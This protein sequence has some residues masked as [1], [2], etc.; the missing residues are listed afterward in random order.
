[1]DIASP[2]A[3]STLTFRTAA[4][5]LPVGG[6][7]TLPGL[8]RPGRHLTWAVQFRG[9]STGGELGL[10]TVGPPTV[11]GMFYTGRGIS[12]VGK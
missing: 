2:T 1:M 9:M 4:G 5:D 11:G 6:P 10:E 12:P 3:G 7:G 8:L